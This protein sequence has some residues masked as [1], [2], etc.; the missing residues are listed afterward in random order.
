M[1]IGIICH[2][3]FPWNR[4]VGRLA[5]TLDENGYEVCILAKSTAKGADY[6]HARTYGFPVPLLNCHLPFNLFWTVWIV[7]KSIREKIDLLIVRELPL[8]F[9]AY[10]AAKILRVPILM[11]MRE[12]YPAAIQ[13]WG[14]TKLWHYFLRNITF[15]KALERLVVPRMDHIFVVVDQ[16]KDRLVKLGIRADKVTVNMNT[17]DASFLQT[18]AELLGMAKPNNVIPVLTY[19]GAVTRHRGIDEILQALR[20]V[21]DCGC[22]VIFRIVGEGPHLDSIARQVKKLSLDDYV[23]IESY[24]PPDRVPEVVYECDIGIVNHLRSEHTETTIPNKLFEYMALGLPVIASDVG[25]IRIIVEKEECGILVEPEDT[26]CLSEA[27]M[28]LCNSPELRKEMGKRGRTAVLDRYNWQ[29]A[30]RE[31]LGVISNYNLRDSSN[32]KSSKNPNNV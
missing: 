10:L 31:L 27:I 13:A 24:Y 28:K 21:L 29:Q 4:G 26:N 1:K 12:N 17:P 11:D 7:C 23:Q 5:K 32:W 16:Q 30:S 20:K 8:A 9:Q 3:R 14:K 19:I 18:A 6:P 22:A 2:C 15:V 25:P